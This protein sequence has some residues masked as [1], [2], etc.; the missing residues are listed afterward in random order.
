MFSALPIV[1]SKFAYISR[2]LDQRKADRHASAQWNVDSSDLEVLLT[3]DVSLIDWSYVRFGL[4][5][6]ANPVSWV[7]SIFICL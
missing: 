2:P 6:K 4:V 5:V 7:S 3:K 1:A